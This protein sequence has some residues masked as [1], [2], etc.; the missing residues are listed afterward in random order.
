LQGHIDIIAKPFGPADLVERV[1][2]PLSIMKAQKISTLVALLDIERRFI[3]E[4]GILKGLDQF[5]KVLGSK[6]TP[7]IRSE[8]RRRGLITEVQEKRHSGK[9]LLTVLEDLFGSSNKAFCVRYF[10]SFFD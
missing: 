2:S 9:E 5:C 3:S 8:F 1:E 10:I 4:E 7:F 6:L